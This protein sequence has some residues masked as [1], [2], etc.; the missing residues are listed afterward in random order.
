VKH[1]LR[2]SGMSY[3]RAVPH[4]EHAL[5]YTNELYLIANMQ[6]VIRTS[7][8]SLRKGSTLYER[9]A[10]HCEQAVRYTNERYVYANVVNQSCH[11]QEIASISCLNL[12]MT[13]SRECINHQSPFFKRLRVNFYLR[14]EGNSCRSSCKL[15]LKK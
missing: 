15:L 7:G 14:D 3:E 12:A 5:R 13:L 9:A 1:S 2:T 4:C 6:Y 10:P 11:K 8:T